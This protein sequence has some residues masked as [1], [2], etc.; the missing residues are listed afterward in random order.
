MACSWRDAYIDNLQGFPVQG[1][2]LTCT[3]VVR[4]C[5]LPTWT[6]FPLHA[7]A[8]VSPCLMLF[9]L[10]L[11]YHNGLVFLVVGVQG[12]VM[13]F[14]TLCHLGRFEIMPQVLLLLLRLQR[15]S[16]FVYW[17]GR[18]RWELLGVLLKA[19]I[20][21]KNICT[22]DFGSLVQISMT[23]PNGCSWSCPTCGSGF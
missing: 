2:K 12:C 1:A 17:Y 8:V 4:F 9:Q 14:D 5:L 10:P 19:S 21:W 13:L 6:S 7:L 23:H 16:L 18:H 11:H 3:F 15:I 20:P 22:C